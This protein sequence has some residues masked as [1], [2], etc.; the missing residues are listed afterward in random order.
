M[1][2]IGGKHGEEREKQEM[3]KKG[4]MLIMAGT[5][6][7]SC[8]ACGSGS[9]SSQDMVPASIGGHAWAGRMEITYAEGFQIDK[10]EDG[11][12][13]ITI[14]GEDQFLIVPE[15]EKVPGAEDTSGEEESGTEETSDSQEEAEADEASGS[16]ETS[17][18]IDDSITVLRQ[19]VTGI[20]LAA[21]AVM[22]MFVS[23][24]SLDDI[25]F[26]VLTADGWYI[27]EA[28]RSMESGN[29]LYAGKYSAPDYELI[30]SEGC[31]LAIE[32]TM[33]YHTPE[34][35]EELESFG[36]PV[37]V[38]YSSYESDPLGRM[39]WIKLY[40]VL[41]G[42]T[43]LAEQV[44]ERQSALYVDTGNGADSAADEDIG[45]GSDSVTDEDSGTGSAPV[46]DEDS[47]S[48]ADSAPTVAFFYITTTGAVNVRK[49]ADYLPR[50][51]EQAGGVYI[52]EDLG[53]EDDTASSTVTM[54]MEE[55]YNAAKDADYLIYNST[56][57]GELDS[58]EDFLALSD[59][60][61]NFKAVSENHVYC[62]TKNLYQ[63]SM[64]LGTIT[65]DIRNMLCGNT[66]NLT[67]LYRIE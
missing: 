54:Q 5:I 3:I 51:I 28:V 32:N 56:I 19:P 53:D 16:R 20:Y 49:S 26:S 60:L 11:Y 12:M 30:L 13:L 41:T 14:R 36:I 62:T 48:V 31:D 8:C 67:Y 46:N 9:Q 61:K 23:L 7:L 2:P 58:M 43:E 64:E 42:E 17:D 6:A 10:Y 38:D 39:E 44:F 24:D 25:R 57:E 1:D 47:E 40:G 4:I 52:F 37:L 66:E 45:N 21:S 22:D 15:G 27:D 18:D 35:K 29:I 33:I 63:A 59:L 50:M 65:S 55:F 34:V